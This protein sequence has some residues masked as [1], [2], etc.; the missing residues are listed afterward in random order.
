MTRELE[1]QLAEQA[2]SGQADRRRLSTRVAALDRKI[3]TATR[4]LL[5]FPEDLRADAFEALRALKDQREEVGRQL[6]ELDAAERQAPTVDPR[7]FK[8]TLAAAADL[9]P[10]WETHEEA[11]L[12]RATL[13]DLVAE[14]RLYYRERRKGERMPRGQESTRRVLCR[15][16]VDLTPCF[17]DMLIT[18][19]RSS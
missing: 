11:E 5:Q 17:A 3:A 16:E 2:R 9:S 1:R 8:A 10:T 13:R 6:R 18:G 15:V 14:V 7:W 19:C 12:L 4:N